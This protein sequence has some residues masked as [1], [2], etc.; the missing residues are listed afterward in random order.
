MK[1]LLGPSFNID[2]EKS[3]QIKTDLH[4]DMLEDYECYLYTETKSKLSC[5][6]IKLKIKEIRNLVYEVLKDEVF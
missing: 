2:D 1:C 4:N 5:S 3:Q 6:T